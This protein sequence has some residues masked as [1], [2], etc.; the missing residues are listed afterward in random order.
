MGQL[1]QAV[2]TVSIKSIVVLRLVH[3]N[4]VKAEVQTGD[5]VCVDCVRCTRKE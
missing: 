3:Q 1:V 5:P 4:T 2:N